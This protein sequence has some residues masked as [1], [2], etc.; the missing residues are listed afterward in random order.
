MKKGT[1][2]TRNTDMYIGHFING[3]TIL[4]HIAYSPEIEIQ[5]TAKEHSEIHHG[6]KNDIYDA[7]SVESICYRWLNLSMAIEKHWNE[8]DRGGE[9][10]RLMHDAIDRIIFWELPRY[11][12]R[13]FYVGEIRLIK[14]VS[15]AR[16]HTKLASG[17]NRLGFRA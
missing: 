13:P 7:E 10:V 14:C 8:I 16:I 2:L 12:F 5:V 17:E 3:Q 11:I 4:H 1:L 6:L 9:P 15:M